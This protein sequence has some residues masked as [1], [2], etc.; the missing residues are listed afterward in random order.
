MTKEFEKA[1]DEAKGNIDGYE[2]NGFHKGADWAYEYLSEHITKCRD[3]RM[4]LAK[5][6]AIYKELVELIDADV[7]TTE[8]YQLSD[9]LKAKVAELEKENE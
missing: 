9:K 6:N 8:E 1:R 5:Q 4:R 3:I 7:L 2:L